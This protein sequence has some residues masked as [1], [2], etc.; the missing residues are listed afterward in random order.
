MCMCVRAHARAY[1]GVGV[2]LG[3]L[4]PVTKVT[5]TICVPL[6][7]ACDCGHISSLPRSLLPCLHIKGVEHR[8]LSRSIVVMQFSNERLPSP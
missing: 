3:H 5:G 4:W 7:I 8:Y 6:V 1:V 2:V